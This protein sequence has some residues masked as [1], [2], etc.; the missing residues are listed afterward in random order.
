MAF[1]SIPDGSPR[2][3]RWVPDGPPQDFLWISDRAPMEALVGFPKGFPDA[4]PDPGCGFTSV[5]PDPKGPVFVAVPPILRP[6]G[7]GPRWGQ[8]SLKDGFPAPGHPPTLAIAVG[9][10]I[11]HSPAITPRI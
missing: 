6:P 1:R 2:E 5:F 10:A 8:W 9:R 11:T 7:L 4:L 3:L